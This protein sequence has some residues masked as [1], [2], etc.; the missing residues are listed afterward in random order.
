MKC[1]VALKADIDFE[2]AHPADLRHMPSAQKQI[3][4]AFNSHC[5]LSWRNPSTD[6]IK[7]TQT[8]LLES[9]DEDVH[10]KSKAAP[11]RSRSPS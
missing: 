8:K 9:F 11:G 4:A 2:K 10:D 6:R 5:N 1:W 3:D 7:D